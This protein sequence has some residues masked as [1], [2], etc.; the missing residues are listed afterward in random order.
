MHA[1][2]YIYVYTHRCIYNLTHCSLVCLSL[3][4]SDI[5]H[6]FMWLFGHLYVLFGEMVYI[7][8]LPIFTLSCFSDIPLHNLFDILRLIP[9]WSLH[10]QIFQFFLNKILYMYTYTCIYIHIYAHYLPNMFVQTCKHTH[11]HIQETLCICMS[12]IQIY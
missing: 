9:H 3:I 8:I 1:Y 10:L 11:I 2:I 6:I 4:I 12:F 5:E 7:D